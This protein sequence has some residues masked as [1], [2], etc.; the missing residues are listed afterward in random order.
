M[1][2]FGVPGSTYIVSLT[3]D[4]RVYIHAK[5]MAL[6]G[7]LLNP[8]IYGSILVALGVS[9]SDLQEHAI[10][11]P[12]YGRPRL[13]APSSPRCR[14]NRTA[15]ST[16]L[17]LSRVYRRVYPAPPATPPYMSRPMWGLR[18][19]CSWDLDLDESHVVEEEIDYGDPAVTAED[20]VDRESLKAFVTQ[21]GNYFLDILEDRRCSRCLESQDRLAGPG[22]ALET[23][24][25]LPLRPGYRQRRH[26]VPRSLPGQIRVSA[27]D[28]DR[29]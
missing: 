21:A 8:V 28:T 14:R 26:H 18:S 12:C 20:V 5:D 11:R 3:L 13:S 16:R 1:T 4:G 17:S 7:R 24:F 23:R 10:S 2:G 19:C 9:P 29:H 6:S 15:H 27:F 22:R 25:R